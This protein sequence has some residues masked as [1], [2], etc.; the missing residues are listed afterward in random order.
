MKYLIT[1][2]CGF[3]GANLAQEVINRDNELIVFD[4]LYR[5][6]AKSNLEW[7]KTLGNFKFIHGDIRNREDI[8]K[9]IKEIKPDYIFHLSGQ[10]AMV[11][12]I[13]NP[14]F[15]FEINVMGSFNLLDSVR[16]YSPDSIILY[17]STNK[18]YGDLLW[19]EYRETDTRFEAIDYPDGFPKIYN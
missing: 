10:V 19:I 6:G 1:G 4:N 13:Q 17:S 11:T 14:R 3:V 9:V 8:E 5:S 2:G 7:L 16:K 12:S 18:V 15:D